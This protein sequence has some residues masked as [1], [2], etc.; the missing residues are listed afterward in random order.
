MQMKSR[1]RFFAV[2]LLPIVF[3][4]SCESSPESAKAKT[5][6]LKL[7]IS[8][9][10]WKDP[11]GNGGKCET[12]LEVADYFTENTKVSIYDDATGDL[13]GKT[14][15]TSSKNDPESR[16]C[17]Y[18]STIQVPKIDSY[19][20]IFASGRGI[21]T[22]SFVEMKTLASEFDETGLLGDIFFVEEFGSN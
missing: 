1:V 7:Y 18:K 17:T 19:R 13:I 15:L 20:F 12:G 16:I 2:I 9:M 5:E 22:R 11:Y 4:A 6:N 3:L 8:I 21:I 14:T 10:T